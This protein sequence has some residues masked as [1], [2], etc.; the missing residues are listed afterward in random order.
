MDMALPVK[1]LELKM[2]S[3]VCMPRLQAVLLSAALCLA[4][5]GAMAAEPAPHWGYEQIAAPT[6]WSEFAPACS[7]NLQSP[8]DLWSSSIQHGTHRELAADYG[9][10]RFEV[11]NNGHTLQATPQ[12]GKDNY[13]ELEGE[14]FDLLQFH[15]HTPSEHRVDGRE[16]AME[17]HLVHGNADGKL[18]V[19]AVFFD[20]GE[21][22]AALGELFERIPGELGQV[23]NAITLHGHIDPEE[24]LPD[25]SRVARYTGSLTTP[26]CSEGV[27]WNIELE[28]QQLSQAQLDALRHV[29]PHNARPIQPFNARAL[30]DDP[31]AP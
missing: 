20:V 17:L 19:V 2:T 30:S 6:Q 10:T 8:I 28:P 23:G 15:V 13:I 21:R 11:V 24:L 18:A 26:P 27:L 12:P 9:D 7:G 1:P 3:P 22:N 4:L 5:P 31:A 14:R 29:Y 16:H 25:H